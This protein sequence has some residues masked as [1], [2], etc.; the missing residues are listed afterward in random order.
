[1][2]SSFPQMAS[3]LYIH[4]AKAIFEDIQA[5]L[6]ERLDTLPWMDN[7]TAGIAKYKVRR[8]SRHPADLQQ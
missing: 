5:S 6:M 1:M 4:K 7:A 3:A 8:P 2:G